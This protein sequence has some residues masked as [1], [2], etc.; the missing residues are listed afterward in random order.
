MIDNLFGLTLVLVLSV[1]D[2]MLTLWLIDRGATELNPIMDYYLDQG[3]HIF[4]LA[5]YLITAFVVIITVVMNYAFLRFFKIQFGQMLKVFAGC[6]AMVVAWELFL[7][8][9]LVM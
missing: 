6:F 5:K 2:G 1:A 9:Q 8:A 7:V 3:P 4:M